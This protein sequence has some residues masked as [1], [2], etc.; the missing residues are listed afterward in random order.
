MYYMGIDV[1][2]SG[3]KGLVISENEIM[4]THRFETLAPGSKT[5]L[6]VMDALLQKTGS[7]RENVFIVATGMGTDR[8]QFVDERK[9]V[10]AC[11]ARGARWHCKNART[12]VD[13]GAETTTAINLSAAGRVS[14]YVRNNKCA[15]GTAMLLKV[16][17]DILQIPVSEM[18]HDEHSSDR[19][20]RLSNTCSVFAESEAI[21]YLSRGIPREEILAGVH[22]SVVDQLMS[23]LSKVDICE[24]IVLTGGSS[25]NKTILKKLSERMGC[26]VYSPP[27]PE[28]ATALGAALLGQEAQ[29]RD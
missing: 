4:A 27:E 21:S 12:I 8:L 25:R 1:G 13:I 9:T 18:D 15:S 3:V 10:L 29:R 11:L 7:K 6:E 20:I 24:D 16:M 19:K 17:S 2:S 22:E 28:M 26:P 5:A 14:E 23:L